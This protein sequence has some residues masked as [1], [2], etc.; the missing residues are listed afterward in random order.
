LT[1]T[2]GSRRRALTIAGIARSRRQYRIK[3]RARVAKPIPQNK[4]AYLLRISSADRTVIEGKTTAGW[5][6]GLA[7][8]NS[9]ATTWDDGIMLAGRRS[10]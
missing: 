6:A 2:T 3:P 5:K 9:F 8:D 7:V 10:W 4:R 1:R